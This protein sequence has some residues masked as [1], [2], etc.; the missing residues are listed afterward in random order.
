MRQASRLLRPLRAC[1]SS[2]WIPGEPEFLK[3]SRLVSGYGHSQ[4]WSKHLPAL[5]G[6][7]SAGVSTRQVSSAAH[8]DVEVDDINRMFAECRDEIEMT[9]EVGSHE[10]RQHMHLFGFCLIQ[11][12]VSVH[13]QKH[14]GLMSNVIIFNDAIERFVSLQDAGTVYFNESADGAKQL[15]GETLDRW[16]KLLESLPSEEKQSLVRS[17]GLKMEQLKAEVAELDHLHEDD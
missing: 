6:T 15:V 11:E 5:A 13:W 9:R 3:Q 10:L 7:F 14:R 8:K 16:Y 1:L 12:R 2:A 17:M 4:T